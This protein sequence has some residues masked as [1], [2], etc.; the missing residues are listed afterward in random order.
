[1]FFRVYLDSQVEPPQSGKEQQDTGSTFN[2]SLSDIQVILFQSQV[3]QIWTLIII[4][5]VDSLKFPKIYRVDFEINLE[6][7]WIN[8]IIDL[9]GKGNCLISK[10]GGLNINPKIP[11]C[12]SGRR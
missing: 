7:F 12:I 10:K 6:D 1:M 9:P 8:W 3:T 2:Q 5:Q 4:Y 11:F